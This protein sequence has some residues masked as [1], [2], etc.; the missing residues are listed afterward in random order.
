MFLIEVKSIVHSLMPFSKNLVL[1]GTDIPTTTVTTTQPST[2]VTS[3]FSSVSSWV[4]LN[5]CLPVSIAVLSAIAVSFLTTKWTYKREKRIESKYGHHKQLNQALADLEKKSREC[6]CDPNCNPFCMLYMDNVILSNGLIDIPLKDR[7]K[8]RNTFLPLAER[9]NKLISEQDVNINPSSIS[10]EEWTNCQD[11]LRE[12]TQ[13]IIEDWGSR[14]V[15]SITGIHRQ[16]WDA[17]ETA[18]KTIKE[19]T[20]YTKRG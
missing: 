18:I 12:F 7:D 9:I 15:D 17:L 19:S 11:T 20:N 3:N 2:A 10:L 14:S 6:Q 1:A 8:C 13:L 16:K 5:I 4:L